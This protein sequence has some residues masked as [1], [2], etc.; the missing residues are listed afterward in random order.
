MRKQIFTLSGRAY[1]VFN[2]IG[3]LAKKQ[4][5]I[6]VNQLRIRRD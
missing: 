3:L 1:Q 4:G 2:I 6:P 5:N